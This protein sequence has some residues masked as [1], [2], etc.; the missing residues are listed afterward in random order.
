MKYEH[1]EFTMLY[2]DDED[3]VRTS[4]G[5]DIIPDNPDTDTIPD[6]NDPNVDGDLWL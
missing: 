1:P 5:D 3:I 4:G 2:I 6:H